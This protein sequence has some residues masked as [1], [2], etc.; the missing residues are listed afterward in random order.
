M[1]NCKP[2]SADEVFEKDIPPEM[3]EDVMNMISEAAL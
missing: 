2:A 1:K 3:Q